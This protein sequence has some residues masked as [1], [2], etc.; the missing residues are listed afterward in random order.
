MKR[1]KQP[2][3]IY[4]DKDKDNLPPDIII[5]YREE[6]KIYRKEIVIIERDNLPPDIIV[7]IRD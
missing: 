2:K 5:T 6:D 3:M 1:T 7:T 4:K